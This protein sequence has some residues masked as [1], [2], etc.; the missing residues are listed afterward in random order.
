MHLELRH[1]NAIL[2]QLGCQLI[3][4]RLV[5]KLVVKRLPARSCLTQVP[6]RKHGRVTT[7]SA[8][9]ARNKP[10]F[11]STSPEIIPTWPT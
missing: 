11:M 4:K 5:S 2:Q 9:F 3:V 1:K 8:A 6:V 10:Y 7:E